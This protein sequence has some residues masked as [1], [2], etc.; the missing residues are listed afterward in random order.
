MTFVLYTLITYIAIE[1]H[2][3]SGPHKSPARRE[4]VIPGA[5][6]N[7]ITQYIHYM[8]CDSLKHTKEEDN[9][10]VRVT[11]DTG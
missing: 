6:V 1:T 2:N 11:I 8:I 7:T 4:V 10:V 5:V 9:I 3:R